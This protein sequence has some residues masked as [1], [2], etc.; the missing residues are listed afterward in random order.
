MS[1][2][3]I[4]LF[5]FGYH[6]W[7]NAT[8]KLIQAV[9][10]VER[11]RG[12]EPPTFVDIRFRKQGR[13]MGFLGDAFQKKLARGRHRWMRS[14]G[15]NRIGKHGGRKC[16]IDKPETAS[17]LLDHALKAHDECRRVIF[18]CHCP[19]PMDKAVISCHRYVVGSLLLKAAKKRG[20]KIEVVEWPGGEP[21][22]L[23]LNVHPDVFIAVAKGCKK[24]IPV[25]KSLS[26]TEI[27]EAPCGSVATLHS[28]NQ[29]LHRF[30][31]PA[32]WHYG[33]W[34]LPV[35]TWW[36]TNPT[37]T[38]ESYLRYQSSTRRR[39]GVEPRFSDK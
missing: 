6:G 20:V 38:L 5:S 16:Q 10:A 8:S 1:K 37:A 36:W 2:Q 17:E 3:P 25:G 13:A 23:D 29:E 19:F 27:A 35:H 33:G 28:G 22:H 14:L 7:G 32:Q 4:T 12:F 9:D 24:M 39:F 30:I 11:A 26:L 18:F 34:Q 21:I 15:N 31:G